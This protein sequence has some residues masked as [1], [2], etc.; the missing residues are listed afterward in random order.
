MVS[1][2]SECWTYLKHSGGKTWPTQKPGFMCRAELACDR[3]LPWPGV[4]EDLSVFGPLNVDRL[5]RRLRNDLTGKPG[6]LSGTHFQQRR[7]GSLNTEPEKSQI[8]LLLH[9]KH[10][11]FKGKRSISTTEIQA[12]RGNPS[13]GSKVGS[14]WGAPSR[15]SVI[16][17]TVRHLNTSFHGMSFYHLWQK[18]KCNGGLSP[19]PA[20]PRTRT[21][22]S[23]A[24]WWGR[25]T[26]NRL[27][28]GGA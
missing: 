12:Y 11:G 21:N 1:V 6:S 25:S 7:A 26:E 24:S 23:R 16:G 18:G 2:P 13:L 15:T 8:C 17:R 27:A 22:Q 3:L 10:L 19:A 14:C 9:P 4:T 20:S 5:G 28:A